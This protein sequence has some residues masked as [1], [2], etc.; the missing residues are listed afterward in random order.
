ML[1]RLNDLPSVIKQYKKTI[2][3]IIKKSTIQAS[4]KSNEKKSLLVSE[5][6][7]K[8]KNQNLNWEIWLEVL[9]LDRFSAREI[10]QTIA[11]RFI[12]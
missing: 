7:D 10:V 5:M 6:I 12:L 1:I 9:I 2:H 8:N 4:K 11:M 3:R